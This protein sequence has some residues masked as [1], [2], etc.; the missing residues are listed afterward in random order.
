MI[1]FSKL[2]LYGR[3][4]NQMFQYAAA[5]SAAL[6][7]NSLLAI[8]NENQVLSRYFNL[9]CKYYFLSQNINL[10]HKLPKYIEHTFNYDKRLE[11]ISDNIDLEGYFQTE[12]YFKKYEVIIREDFSFKKEILEKISSYISTI[13]VPNKELVSLHVRRGDYVGLQNFHP[14]CTVD[15]YKSA[16]NSFNNIRLLVFSDDIN[17]CKS[18]IISEDI[19]YSSFN[20]EAEDMCAM[21]MC[22]HNIIA[23]SSFSWWAAWLNNNKNKI[24]IAPKNWFGQDYK[25]KNTS[26]LYCENWRII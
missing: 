14:L 5:K 12:K 3:M 26:D 23:N 18:N 6:T 7:K 13:K 11:S 25:D 19:I 4:G 2:G 21:S 8:P 24:V 1:T 9:N 22:D 10:I 20:N 17:W 15:Y 16:I